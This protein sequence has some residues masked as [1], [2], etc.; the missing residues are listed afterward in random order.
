MK[1]IQIHP[2]EILRAVST[3]K[4]ERLERAIWNKRTEPTNLL[5]RP[6]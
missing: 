6:I 1:N 4:E 2:P 5:T 3:R